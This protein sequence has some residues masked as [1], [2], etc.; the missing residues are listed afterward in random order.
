MTGCPSR[1]P[2]GKEVEIEPHLVVE[3]I[4]GEGLGHGVEPIVAQVGPHQGCLLPF[5]EAIIVLVVEELA[6][7]VR[8]DL[9][10]RKGKAG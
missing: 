3:L 8:V 9:Q 4:D 7:V 10:H 2:A 6:A 5:D 1:I